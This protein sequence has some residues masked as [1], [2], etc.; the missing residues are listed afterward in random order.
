LDESV[1]GF[2]NQLNCNLVKG[3][4][5][6]NLFADLAGFCFSKTAKFLRLSRM[7]DFA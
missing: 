3:M 7:Q 2:Q 1:L 4:E 5:K 6:H